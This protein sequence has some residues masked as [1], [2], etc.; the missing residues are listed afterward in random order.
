MNPIRIA[1]VTLGVIA[2]LLLG[3]LAIGFLLPS[4]WTVERTAL[5]DAPPEAI[6]PHLAGAAAWERW[7]P[8]PE[9]GS[10]YFGPAEGAGSGR[11]WDDGGYGSGEF[12]VTEAVPGER[13]GYDV[14]VEG[15]SIR[16]HG[17]IRLAPEGERTR[18]LWREE[19]DFGWNPLLGYI[20]IR[21]E[22]LQ[23]GQLEASLQSLRLL[24]EE[25]VPITPEG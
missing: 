25:G 1:G 7:T 17:E 21:M 11:R 2:A 19:G 23:G 22:E 10:E 18:I 6:Y 15:G 14:L 4:G 9:S 20:A 3:F 5:F 16:I 12:V 24:V 13:V 8:S